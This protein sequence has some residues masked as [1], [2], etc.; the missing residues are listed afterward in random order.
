MTAWVKMKRGLF[1]SPNDSGYTG[2]RDLAGRYT[3]AEAMA[4][5]NCKGVT[6]MRLDAA[7]EFSPACFDD[8]ARQ[9]LTRQRDALR[10]QLRL[11]GYEPEA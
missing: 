11:L 5:T 10:A 9:H 7:P 2:I 6:A 4:E 3:E 1:Y 8:L